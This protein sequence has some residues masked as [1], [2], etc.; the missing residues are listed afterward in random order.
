MIGCWW[1][2]Y[3]YFSSLETPPSRVF[4]HHFLE[5]HHTTYLHH[6]TVYAV[7]YLGRPRIDCYR[8]GCVSSPFWTSRNDCKD[9]V[10]WL[11]LGVYRRVP[12]AA[13]VTTR[14]KK[15]LPRSIDAHSGVP[16]YTREECHGLS[17]IHQ[18]SAQLFQGKRTTYLDTTVVHAAGRLYTP[19]KSTAR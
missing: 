3:V 7:D 8:T 6:D 16:G 9:A 10:Y 11:D 2:P 19:G 17:A 5:H 12:C 1:V 18:A 14:R 13:R 4:A 15:L